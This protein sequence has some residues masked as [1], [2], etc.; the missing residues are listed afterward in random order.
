MTPTLNSHRRSMV[1]AKLESAEQVLAI[2]NQIVQLTTEIFVRGGRNV[3]EL[4]KRQAESSAKIRALV[5][6]IAEHLEAKKERELFAAASA[7]WSSVHRY[8]QSLHVLTNA[9]KLLQSGTMTTDVV[10]PLLIDMVSWRAFIEYLRADLE[11]AGNDWEQKTELAARTSDLLRANQEVK[12][13][14]AERKRIEERL[15]Q[16]T[17]IIESSSDAIVIYTLGGTIVSWNA[18]AERVYG[19]TSG[20]VLG[21]SGN[22]L[23]APDRFDEL[24][25]VLEKVESGET[26]KMYETVHL[27][28]HEQRI[29]VSTA[30]SPVKDADGRTVGAAAIT[31]DISDRKKAEE[32]FYK[33]FQANPE[34]ITIA[35]LAD[36]VYI[37]V[38]ESFLRV[39]GCG[40]EEVIGHA[41]TELKF[42]ER[43]EDRAKLLKA[44]EKDGSVRDVEITFVTKCGQQRIGL[45]SAEIIE[46]GGEK[47]VISIF[48][49]MTEQ[50]MLEGQLRKAQRMEAIGQLSGGIAHDFNNLLTVMIG[51]SQLLEDRMPPTDGLKKS[52]EE[53]KKAGNHAASLTRQLLAF[54]RQQVLE[55]RVLDLNTVVT[56]LEKMLRRL[57]G[58]NIE[59]TTQ[60]DQKLAHIK[61]DPG[62]MQQVIVNLAVNARDAMPNGG[63]LKIRTAN[64]EVGSDRA[65]VAPGSYVLL[66]ISDTGVGLDAETQTKV[67]EP[68]FTTKEVGKGTGL[69]LSTV[70]GVIKQS[71]GYIT[72]DSA[73]GKGAKFT[74]YLPRTAEKT[75]ARAAGP[76]K[77]Q[78]LRGTETILLVEDAASVRELTRDWLLAIGYTVLEADCPEAALRILESHKRPIHLLLTDVIMPGMN[79]AALA[80]TVMQTRPA[81]KILYISGYTGFIDHHSIAPEAMIVAKPFTRDVLLGKIR[82]VLSAELEPAEK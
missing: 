3:E 2:S 37:D 8:E 44:L 9:N 11:G 72:I 21:K 81:A 35:R 33:A 80:R 59:M 61:A 62:Q 29:D 6:S 38:N 66:E 71:S 63:K 49:D 26:V 65:V 70:Y 54:S 27:R 30:I 68:F 47:C 55:Q 25:V 1:Q 76:P 46:I 53:I 75:S 79:G 78:S 52:V 31:R 15:S 74:I 24:T 5:Q 40:R 45:N 12:S 18:G 50:K 36:G 23:L 14:I 82:E 56:D 58:E 22:V 13:K 16:L 43:A 32:R 42:W 41:A 39:T 10:L 17:S 4:I 51:H 34:P 28:K 67:F 57:I 69:G 19:Y 48:R 60:L 7:R 20:E 73:P 77:A 64:A